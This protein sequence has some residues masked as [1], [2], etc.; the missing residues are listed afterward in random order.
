MIAIDNWFW[1]TRQWAEYSQACGSPA[2][3]INFGG[4][5]NLVVR[6]GSELEMK[7]AMSK[8]HRAAI[9]Q[10]EKAGIE[11]E[12]YFGGNYP[13]HFEVF[14]AL[15]AKDAGRITRPK[16]TWDL[17]QQWVCDRHALLVMVGDEAAALYITHGMGAY[18]AS[19]ARNP[20]AAPE[21]HRLLGTAL[22][23]RAMRR[24]SATGHRW[25]D[26]GPVEAEPSPKV[27]AIESYKKHWGAEVMRW[28]YFREA[29]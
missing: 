14:R 5:G 1:G 22:M 2:P 29:A 26:L 23:W 7:R 15:H 27:A 6:L 12:T 19:T 11:A 21:R 9:T 16:A 24:L 25:L 8:G 17:M 20:A 3:T 18:Y 13:Y 28:P 4:N 10:A